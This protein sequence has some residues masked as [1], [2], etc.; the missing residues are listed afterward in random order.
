MSVYR[1]RRPTESAAIART[2]RRPEY[3]LPAVFADMTTA[4]RLNDREGLRLL[5]CRAARAMNPGVGA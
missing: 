2:A 1:V 4:N 3:R 5:A